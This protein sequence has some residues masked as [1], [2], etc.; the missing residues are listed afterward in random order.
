M[1][2]FE[3]MQGLFEILKVD[4]TPYK[5]WSEYNEWEMANC[6]HNVVLVTRWHVIQTFHLIH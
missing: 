3:S 5:H 6:M 2:E 4:K 1:I